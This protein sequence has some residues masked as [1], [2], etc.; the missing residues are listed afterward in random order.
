[1]AKAVTGHDEVALNHAIIEHFDVGKKLALDLE[2]DRALSPD[3]LAY[4]YESL[5]TQGAEVHSVDNLISPYANTVRVIFTRPSIQGYGFVGTLAIVGVIALMAAIGTGI[6]AWRITD[7]I[8]QN[9]LPLL[10][11]GGGLAGL[12]IWTNRPEAR[13]R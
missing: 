12:L 3:E 1:M 5:I 9:F 10:L 13:M 4:V 7:I 6:F 11:L 8:Q 2:V